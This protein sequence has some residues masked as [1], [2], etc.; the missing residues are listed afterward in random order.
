[1]L[2]LQVLVH[3]SLP[4]TST[5]NVKVPVVVGVNTGSAHVVQLNPEPVHAYLYVELPS[6][7]ALKVT[8]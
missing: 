2:M 4:V 7:V 8:V 1:M 5:V 6:A 3:P